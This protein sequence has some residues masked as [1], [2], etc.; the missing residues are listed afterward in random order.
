MA[1]IYYATHIPDLS[2]IKAADLISRAPEFNRYA[3]LVKVEHIF[4]LKKSM[5]SVSM[6]TFTF[7]HLNSP[8]D[9]API[10]ANADFR[11]WDGTWHFN[12]FDYGCP[13]DCRTVDIDNG[14]PRHE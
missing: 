5:D 7:Q 13:S 11:Y 12:Q 1:T 10:K 3:R 8:A 14:I 9:A 6:G 2:P 4:R